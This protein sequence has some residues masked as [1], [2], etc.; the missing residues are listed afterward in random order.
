MGKEDA[1]I[2]SNLQSIRDWVRGIGMGM[3]NG[4][5]YDP[6]RPL[7]PT[8]YHFGEEYFRPRRSLLCVH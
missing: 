4:M 1:S 5:Y 3:I 2:P 8:Y 6:R 7:H